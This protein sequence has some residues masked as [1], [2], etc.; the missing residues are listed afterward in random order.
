[1]REFTANTRD[2]LLN[3]ERTYVRFV[4]RL[5]HQTFPFHLFPVQK[6][7]ST[8]SCTLIQFKPW[9]KVVMSLKF[10]FFSYLMQQDQS[11]LYDH[12]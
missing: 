10:L 11:L 2:F 7:K 6:F 9:F 4:Q 1:M 5:I 3:I 8:H 12:N